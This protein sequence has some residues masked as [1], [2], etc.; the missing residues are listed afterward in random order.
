MISNPAGD[1]HF[2]AGDLLVVIGPPDK[3]ARAMVLFDNP[4]DGSN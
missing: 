3:I 2:C 4:E 1:L